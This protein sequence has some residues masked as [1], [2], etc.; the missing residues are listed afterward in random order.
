[1]ATRRLIRTPV[2]D[3]TDDL[4]KAAREAAKDV[5]KLAAKHLPSLRRTARDVISND[6]PRV[7]QELPRLAAAVQRE[8]PRLAEVVGRELR[9]RRKG[10]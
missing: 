5:S 1:M 4:R 7:R 6:L 9:R 2:S 3:S 10:R 8:L